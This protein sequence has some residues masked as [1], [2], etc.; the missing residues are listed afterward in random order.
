M[1]VSVWLQLH[2]AGLLA[3][4]TTHTSDLFSWRTALRVSLSRPA[5]TPAAD[6]ESVT[7]RFPGDSAEACV[8][9]GVPLAAAALQFTLHY[10]AVAAAVVGAR[11]VEEVQPTFPAAPIPDALGL[12]WNDHEDF[13]PRF[14][15]KSLRDHR[16]SR[17]RSMVMVAV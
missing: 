16:I 5:P 13:Y 2:F 3:I 15:G 9:Y 8:R 17:V 7:G 10:P 12:S 4:D 14:W 1:D 6:P 11:T